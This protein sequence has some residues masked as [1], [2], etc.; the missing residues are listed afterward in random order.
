MNVVSGLLVSNRISVIVQHKISESQQFV[1]TFC[2]G[3]EEGW[4]RA[5]DAIAGWCVLAE[6][7][8]K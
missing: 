7:G 6:E 2:A 5:G 1:M 4:R 3:M 8:E